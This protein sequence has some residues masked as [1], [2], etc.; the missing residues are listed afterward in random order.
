[1]G[2]KQEVEQGQWE[3]LNFSLAD[4]I[5][6]TNIWFSSPSLMYGKIPFPSPQHLSR[7]IWPEVMSVTSWSEA[8]EVS[9]ESLCLLFPLLGHIWKSIIEMTNARVA[10]QLGSMGYQVENNCPGEPPDLQT[11]GNNICC[12]QPL[13]I[14]DC[15][16]SVTC[17]LLAII[18]PEPSSIICQMGIKLLCKAVVM[19]AWSH[20]CEMPPQHHHRD[21]L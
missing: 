12:L 15:Y 5:V 10:E 14:W 2:H 3:L 7:A 16:D 11:G 20:A 9:C 4:I 1:M 21:S 8:E 13:R 6:F 18:L 17:L 19:D